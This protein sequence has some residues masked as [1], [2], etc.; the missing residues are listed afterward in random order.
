M[1]LITAEGRVDEAVAKAEAFAGYRKSDHHCLI[2]AIIYGLSSL[3]LSDEPERK[4]EM[5]TK[6]VELIRVAVNDL[7]FDQISVLRTDPDF[8]MFH[9]LPQF[10]SLLATSE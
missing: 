3:H 5:L 6:G 9:N 7:Q 8:Y 4:Q 10:Q 1:K 2:S